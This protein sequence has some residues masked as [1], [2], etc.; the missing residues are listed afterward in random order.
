MDALLKHEI[1]YNS[2]AIPA[3]VNSKL[4]LNLMEPEA[5][6][7][8]WL[9]VAE[10]VLAEVVVLTVVVDRVVEAVTSAS[11][12]VLVLSGMTLNVDLPAAVVV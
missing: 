5:L 1:D 2:I 9:P 12:G 4:R 7:G 10:V 11:D 6:L 8:V 3:T